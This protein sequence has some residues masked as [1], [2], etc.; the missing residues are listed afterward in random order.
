METTFIY[1]LSDPITGEI[2]YIGKANNPKKRILDH[3]RENKTSNRSHKISWIKSLI[4]K[5][6]L[7]IVEIV[8]EVPKLYWE[9][10][11]QYWISQFKSWGFNLTNISPGGYNNNYKRTTETKQKMR[12]SKL[13]TT[14]PKEQRKKISE[15]VKLK[16]K[17]NPLYNRG[18]GN[19]RIHLDKDSLYQKYIVENLSLNK[20]ANFF[21]VSKKT[22]FTNITEYGFRKE[23]S[24]WINQVKSNPEKT[25]L[26]FDKDG[27]FLSEWIGLKNITKKLNINSANIANCCRG[28][29]KSA[30]GFIWK[31]KD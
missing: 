10:W 8:D 11:E 22:V 23:K 13:G 6:L 29:A 1:S 27:N 15:S 2:R 5:D 24:F 21:K 7:P 16:A 19:S 25:I 12:I 9:F 3:V 14:L 20:C 17:E 31:Y 26:Q 18:G 30:G 4:V 28:V